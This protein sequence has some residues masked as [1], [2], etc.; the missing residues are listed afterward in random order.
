M[1]DIAR[2]AQGKSFHAIHKEAVEKLRWTDPAGIA[3]EFVFL[4]PPGETVAGGGAKRGQHG[5]AH[6]HRPERRP[7]EDVQLQPAAEPARVL[8]EGWLEPRGAVRDARQ[9]L[10][11]EPLADPAGV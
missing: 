1:M 7:I 8:L 2:H 9:S 3:D 6:P 4:R 11:V 10:A 5:Q